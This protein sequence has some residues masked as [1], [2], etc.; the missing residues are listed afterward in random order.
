MSVY[1]KL[2]AKGRSYKGCVTP[3]LKSSWKMCPVV[4]FFGMFEETQL[5]IFQTFHVLPR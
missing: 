2:Y 1:T 4:E 5:S 3:E